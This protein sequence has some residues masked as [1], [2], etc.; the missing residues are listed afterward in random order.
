MANPFV[1]L[2]TILCQLLSLLLTN[3]FGRRDHFSSLKYLLLVQID[4]VVRDVIDNAQ[5]LSRRLLGRRRGIIQKL[6]I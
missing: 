4:V 6:F 5:A 1:S 3:L 2:S